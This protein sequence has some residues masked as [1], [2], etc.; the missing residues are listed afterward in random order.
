MDSEARYRWL[1][2]VDRLV[3]ERG[4]LDPLEYLLAIGCVEYADYRE[5]RHRR[6]PELQS[7]FTIPVEEVTAALAHAQAY[8]IEQHLSVEVCPPIAWDKDQGPLSVGPSKTL[9]ELCTHRLVRPRNRLQGDLFQDSA[10]TLALDQVNRA[11]AEHRFDAAHSALERLRELSDTDGILNDYRRLIQ[12]AEPCSSEPAERLRDLEEEVAP[13]AARTLGARARDYLAPLW[14]ELAERLEGCLFTPSSPN[15]HASYAYAQAGAWN[16]VA[17]AIEGE[18]GAHPHSL[19][20]VRLAEAYA[21][22]SRREAARRV[23]TR[24]C[25]E[26]PQT[27]AQTLAHAPGDEGLAQ[28]WHEF[29]SADPELPPEDF[30]AWLLIADL[31]QR[32]HVPSGLAPDSRTGR[33]YA[34]VY[35]LVTTDGAMPARAELHALRPDLLKIFLDRRRASHDA[36]MKF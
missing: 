13:L 5:W 34:A 4:E 12:A 9:A 11:L 24:L 20:I 10:K 25:W 14:A 26:H 16:R 2:T 35:Q 19:L 33:V 6:R 23:W 31:A 7:A 21:R 29:I 8:G 27:A 30:P 15:L 32:S 3:L 28:R 17:E 1:S 22:Q 18:L 36:I